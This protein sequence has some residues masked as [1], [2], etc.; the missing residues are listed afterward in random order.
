MP[1]KALTSYADVRSSPTLRAVSPQAFDILRAQWT[2]TSSTGPTSCSATSTP[3]PRRADTNGVGG[4]RGARR[5]RVRAR[6]DQ[7]RR[8]ARRRRHGSRHRVVPQ[9]DVAGLQDRRRHRSGRCCRSSGCSR[10]RLPRSASWSGRWSSKRPTMRWRRRRGSRR[11]DPAV[12]RVLICTPDKDL[13]QCVRGTRVVQ[14]HRRT[15]QDRGRGRGDRR[16]SAC[17]PASIPDYLALVGDAADGYPGLPGWGA[18][19]AAAVLAQLR[20]HRGHSRRS[21]GVA[22]QRRGSRRPG[23][24]AG[25]RTGRWRCCFASWQRCAPTCRCSSRSSSCDGRDRRRR[26]PRF[27]KRFDAAVTGPD[28]RAR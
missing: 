13:A 3:C 8:D 14:W 2:S 23:A 6:P 26:S 15:Q 18:K 22:R 25:A 11:E 17:R 12:E 16:S 9:P 5:G 10:R 1:A 4:R 24:D 7:P 20:P 21:R 19:S 27:G 28:K